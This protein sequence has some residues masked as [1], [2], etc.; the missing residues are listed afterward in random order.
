M[1]LTNNLERE[2]ECTAK[3]IDWL[4]QVWVLMRDGRLSR[5]QP[6]PF[7]ERNDLLTP[8]I[9][10]GVLEALKGIFV[11]ELRNY[12]SYHQRAQGVSASEVLVPPGFNKL[13]YSYKLA[14][15]QGI[16]RIFGEYR[17]TEEEALAAEERRKADAIR[18]EEARLWSAA[19]PYDSDDEC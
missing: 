10:N 8:E 17:E 19:H 1:K 13:D 4:H 11:S 7:Y 14:I 3:T 6:D 12:L 9:V 16:D 2:K 18:V 15:V 5:L